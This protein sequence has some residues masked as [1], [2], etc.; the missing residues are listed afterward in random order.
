MADEDVTVEDV[1]V[2]DVAADEVFAAEAVVPSVVVAA[3]AAALDRVVRVDGSDIVLAVVLT[4]SS[5]QTRD[6]PQPG[7]Y[8]V[9][10]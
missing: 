9:S 7:A 3:A 10:G 8:W 2:E 6:L 1:A 4:L 5:S